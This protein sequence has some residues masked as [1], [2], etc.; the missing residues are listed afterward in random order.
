MACWRYIIHNICMCVFIYTYIQERNICMCVFIYT[1]IQ[2]RMEE[3]LAE[4]SEERM[5]FWPYIIRVCVCLYIPAY[6]YVCAGADGRGTSSGE[7]RAHGI[8]AICNV[9]VCVCV[10]IYIHICM[11]VYM[12]MYLYR[13]GWKRYRQRRAKSAW[14]FV[15]FSTTS[16]TPSRCLGF[17]DR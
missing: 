17:S 8:S 3:I 10:Y 1:Y 16:A 7:R 14:H 11:C 6:L 5:A 4:A 9:C 15:S 13:S 12:H 2:E